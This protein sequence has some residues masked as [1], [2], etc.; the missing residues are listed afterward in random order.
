MNVI[1]V[2]LKRAH[3]HLGGLLDE[4]IDG[5]VVV[6]ENATRHKPVALLVPH[7]YLS[8]I[9]RIVREDQ[10]LSVG[11]IIHAVCENEE[12]RGEYNEPTM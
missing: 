12:L 6:L 7:Q 1:T 5:N 2:P 3:H 11:Q 4:V 9:M 8:Q 10:E